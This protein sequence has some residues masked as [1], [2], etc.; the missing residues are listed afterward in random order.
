MNRGYRGRSRKQGVRWAGSK[1]HDQVADWNGGIE[2][3][4]VTITCGQ[5]SG[6]SE[7]TSVQY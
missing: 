7:T 3:T 5:E 2:E 4:P 6:S 1:A